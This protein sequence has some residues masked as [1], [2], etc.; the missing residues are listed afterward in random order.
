MTGMI[1]FLFRAVTRFHLPVVSFVAE[2]K[3]LT[4]V[5]ADELVLGLVE[6]EAVESDDEGSDGIDS[7]DAGVTDAGGAG[8]NDA[9]GAVGS[10]AGG[11]DDSDASGADRGVAG[12]ADR[13]NAGDADGSGADGGIVADA[14]VSDTDCG[15]AGGGVADK[16][17]ND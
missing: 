13:G 2:A 12:G 16:E 9:G 1:L 17:V 5:E 3:D 8:G 15:C 11:A 6:G 7:D 14:V 4:A 10:D